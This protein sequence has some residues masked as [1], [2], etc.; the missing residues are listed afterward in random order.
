MKNA[1]PLKFSLTPARDATA[2][3][4][5]RAC[6]RCHSAVFNVSRRLSDLFL[7]LFIPLRRYR[8]ISMKCSWEGTLR[9]KKKQLPETVR[10]APEPPTGQSARMFAHPARIGT[11]RAMQETRG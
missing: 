10:I 5:S 9:E 8:C 6:P 3:S 11:V 1:A 2:S 7:S 4:H